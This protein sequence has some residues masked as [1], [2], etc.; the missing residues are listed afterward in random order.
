MSWPAKKNANLG[1]PLEDLII[2]QND[3]Y[4]RRGLAVVH[5]VPT[6]WLPLRNEEGKI[7]GA[8]VDKQTTVD[9]LGGIKGLGAIAFD[10][11]HTDGNGIRRDRVEP[12]QAEFLD[13]YLEIGHLAYILAGYRMLDFFL[14]PWAEWKQLPSIIRKENMLTEWRAGKRGGLPDWLKVVERLVKEC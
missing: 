12:H 6:E 7:T 3:I 14:V 11:K 2:M 13:N 10:A 9:F 8:K 5:K 4:R 1:K